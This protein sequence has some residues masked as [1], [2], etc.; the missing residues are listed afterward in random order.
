MTI[1]EI[2]EKYDCSVKKPHVIIEVGAI[3]FLVAALV[4][5]WEKLI[6]ETGRE[7]DNRGLNSDEASGYK[8]AIMDMINNLNQ[9]KKDNGVKP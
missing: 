2:I 6:P 7:K 9:F 3:P 4:A 5:E 8:Y 1:K